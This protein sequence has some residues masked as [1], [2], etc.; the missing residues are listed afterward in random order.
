VETFKQ[1]R[2]WE[3]ERTPG[4]GGKEKVY[5]SHMEAYCLSIQL[6]NTDS[7]MHVI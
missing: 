6:K 5:K 1:G 3:C 2:V 4:G 7:K